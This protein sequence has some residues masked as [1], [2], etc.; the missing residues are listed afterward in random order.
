MKA[1][2]VELKD[3]ELV[4][5]KLMSLGALS[6][7]HKIIKQGN[8]IFF[9]VKKVVPGF[10]LVEKDFD[11]II[12]KD[13][14]LKS[15]L[16]GELSDFELS[17]LKSAFDVVGDIAI[18]EIDDD[19]RDKE[20]IIASA[21]L[22]NHKNIKT[23]L[24]K[25]DKHEGDFRTQKMKWLAGLKTKEAVHKEN[26]VSILVDVE[27]VYFSPRLST[28]RKRISNLVKN[29]EE[30]LVMFSGCAPYPCV[31][32]KNTSAKHITGIELNPAGHSYGLKNLDFNKCYNV[33]LING[34]VNVESS[35]VYENIIGLKSSISNEQ[36][37]HRL[38]LNPKILELYLKEEDLSDSSFLEKR[39]VELK[40]K[41]IE[42]FLHM[43]FFEKSKSV[44]GGE[45]VSRVLKQLKKLGS[46]C[47]RHDVRAIIHITWDD[48]VIAEK[49][50]IANIKELKEF[51][52]YFFF[53]NLCSY[54]N[55]TEDIL[56]ISK[57]A[58]I[59]N[60]C[61][62]L[63]HLYLVYKDN[64]KL[65]N[66]IVE[67]QKKFNTYFHISDSDGFKEGL[68]LGKGLIDFDRILPFVNKGILEVIN[69][70]EFNPVEMFDSQIAL[71]KHKRFFDRI[72]MPLPKNAEDFL[73]AALS[74][75]KKGT[76][77][78][79]Y[80][81]LHESEFSLA[82]EKVRL[83]CKKRGFEY[84]KLNFIKAGQ[85]SPRTYRICLDFKVF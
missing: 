52:D 55:K 56:R 15:L 48:P 57:S 4:K 61:I 50:I 12:R 68:S 46:I 70:D 83:A 19:L 10:V 54:Y 44:L 16:K 30:V 21:L 6:N 1:V 20:K 9:P 59:K 45:D 60:V 11:E 13:K 58:G 14:S 26:D 25:D 75:V 81:F 73:D 29:G 72:L 43:P 74:V 23:V 85:Q 84:E 71:H 33:T 8:Y 42:V 2:K 36:L 82:E 79:F 27:K 18:L 38:K 22:E 77:I 69:K 47:T 3:A 51:Y 32:S 28:E 62:D 17:K 40:N 65:V 49:K 37:M 31:L 7:S 67:M 66:H 64:S 34:D 63:A 39:I 78:H 35:R 53:E 41:G 76:V 24:R 5:N 80:N